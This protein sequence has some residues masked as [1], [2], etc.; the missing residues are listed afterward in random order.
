[1]VKLNKNGAVNY[2][3]IDEASYHDF[4]EEYN[5][6]SCNE[7]GEIIELDERELSRHLYNAHQI[8]VKKW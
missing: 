8:E 2:K 6:W 1:M 7:C 3:I 5:G 4:F